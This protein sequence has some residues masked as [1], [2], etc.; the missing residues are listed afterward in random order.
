MTE[1]WEITHA[2]IKVIGVVVKIVTEVADPQKGITQRNAAGD[3]GPKAA[4]PT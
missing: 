2:A 1:M 3:A 4:D